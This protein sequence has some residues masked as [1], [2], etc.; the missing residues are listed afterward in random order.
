MRRA[1]GGTFVGIKADASSVELGTIA[2][3]PGDHWNTLSIDAKAS[4]EPVVGV[5]EIK[6]YKRCTS[7]Q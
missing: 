5:A 1:V 3:A 4:Q 6:L 2:I 7:T